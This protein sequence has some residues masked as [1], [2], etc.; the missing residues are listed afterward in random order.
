MNSNLA[1]APYEKAKEVSPDG[2]DVQDTPVFFDCF[3]GYFLA[4]RPHSDHVLEDI[5]L[6]PGCFFQ[7]LLAVVPEMHTAIVAGVDPF[8]KLRVNTELIEV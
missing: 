8:D 1:F 3:E 2:I 5:A 4:S 7:I 6:A